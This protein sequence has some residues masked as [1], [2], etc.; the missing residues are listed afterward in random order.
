MLERF[1]LFKRK[2][3]RLEHSLALPTLPPRSRVKCPHSAPRRRR[4][5]CREAEVSHQCE[6]VKVDI[7]LSE[8]AAVD[9]GY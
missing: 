7:Y 3:E 9:L 1:G 6:L 8:P 2:E 5:L 4:S